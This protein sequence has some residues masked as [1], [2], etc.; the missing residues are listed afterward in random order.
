MQEDTYRQFF[1]EKKEAIPGESAVVLES[2]CL[3]IYHYGLDNLVETSNS[4]SYLCHLCD[5]ELNRIIRLKTV[6]LVSAKLSN[7]PPQYS[8]VCISRK[9]SVSS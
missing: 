8:Q 4:R 1:Q 5:G 9:R 2:T 7:L 3:E 6:N